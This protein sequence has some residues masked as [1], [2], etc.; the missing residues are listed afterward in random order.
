MT[1]SSWPSWRPTHPFWRSS[2]GRKA[3]L[4]VP[5]TP[6]APRRWPRRTHGRDQQLGWAQ[7]EEQEIWAQSPRR[8]GWRGA[9]PLQ[10]CGEH[11]SGEPLRELP[12][13]W[14]TSLL[15]YLSGKKGRTR[16]HRDAA[17]CICSGALTWTA[18]RP[19]DPRARRDA[20]GRTAGQGG[21]RPVRA[22]SCRTPPFPGPCRWSCS[23]QSPIQ[24]E[25]TRG[26]RSRPRSCPH[27]P[28]PCGGDGA[29]AE[30]PLQAQDLRVPARGACS[31]HRTGLVAL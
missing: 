14:Q 15:P 25:Q 1:G 3:Q 7:R 18:Q 11:G 28:D 23:A 31:V 9:H 8:R 10:R 2:R 13:T 20:V 17:L 5:G 12:P 29:E 27:G 19:Q 4:G 26:L 6:P 30:P 22:G 21:A 16:P 24:C